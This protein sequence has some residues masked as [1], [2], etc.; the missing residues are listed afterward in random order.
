MGSEELSG[1]PWGGISWGLSVPRNTEAQSHQS[2]AR[3]ACVGNKPL[4]TPAQP[5]YDRRLYQQSS[6]A[7]TFTHE[8]SYDNAGYIFDSSNMYTY[9]SL[10]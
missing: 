9:G 7:S 5:M 6:N 1:L 4:P 8:T 3:E 2:S 10:S